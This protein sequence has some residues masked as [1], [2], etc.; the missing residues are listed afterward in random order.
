MPGI[1]QQPRFKFGVFEL[2]THSGELRKHG[3]KVRL[4]SQPLQTLSILLENAGQ[5]VTREEIQKRLWPDSTFVDFDNAIN[6]T[7]R[8]LRDALGDSAENPLFIETLA[9][10]GYRFIYP[11]PAADAPAMPQ[12]EQ[13]RNLPARRRLPRAAVAVI[14]A[15]VLAAAALVFWTANRNGQ[16]VGIPSPAVPLTSYLGLQQNPSFSPD[17]ARVAFAWYQPAKR[18]SGIYV[19]SIGPGDP[20]ALT[21]GEKGD[22]APAWSPDG[23]FIAFMRPRDAGH[24][25]VMIMASVGGQERHVTD[26]ISS[27]AGVPPF[28][29]EWSVGS[30]L[31]WS[32]N[33]KWLIGLEP[34][35]PHSSSPRFRGRW[36]HCIVTRRKNLGIQPG[37]Y[38]H[39][40]DVGGHA[41]GRGTATPDVRRQADRR[42]RLDRQRTCACLRVFPQRKAG[43]VA[44]AS[45]SQEQ[46]GPDQCGRPRS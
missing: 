3:I 7:I 8:K 34:S 30:P 10:R 36:V 20:V 17:G 13:K 37:R 2:D 39:F 5:V 32:P 25:A 18:L 19:K 26:L 16:N 29:H 24:T 38:L 41:S 44:N 21:T 6:S 14:A 46:P 33:G 43:N 15:G 4:Q 45:G 31:T 11:I 23:Q 22:F 27:G 40:T 28:N 9:R 42:A 12:V 1:G 35:G